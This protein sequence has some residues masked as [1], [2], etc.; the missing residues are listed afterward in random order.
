MSRD[1]VRNAF[2][3]LL[4]PYVRNQDPSGM[5][6]SSLLAEDL[7]V[8]STRFVDLVLD[9]EDK[10][11]IRVGDDDVDRFRRVGDAIDLISERTASLS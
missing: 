6:E 2:F 3:D 1:E 9:A 8:N 10:F 5:T 7:G 11:K 4:K